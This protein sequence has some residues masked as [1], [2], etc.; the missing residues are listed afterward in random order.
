M[1]L[2]A[3]FGRVACFALGVQSWESRTSWKHR[4][5][6]RQ[7]KGRR[8]STRLGNQENPKSSIILE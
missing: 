2:A 8:I 5:M 1:T 6:G 7:D 4:D 3:W